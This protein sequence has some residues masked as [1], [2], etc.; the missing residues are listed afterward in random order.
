MSLKQIDNPQTLR[1]EYI[2][3]LGKTENST[4]LAKDIAE[5][6]FALD[7]TVYSNNFSFD[8]LVYNAFARS[9]IDDSI[10]LHPE[11]L[12]IVNH[13]RENDA[14]IISAPTSFGKTFCIFEYIIRYQPKNVVLIV[15][16]L[17]LVDEY[18]KKII[19]KFR[20]KFSL[21]KIH[22]S[23][24]EDK[25]YDF[26]KANIFILTH[27]RV[28]QESSYQ[29][30]E[31]IDFMVIDEVYK[32]ETDKNDDR[33][34]VLNM[35]YYYLSQKAEKYVLLAPFIKS[36]EDTDVLEKTPVF[37][38]TNYS[39]VVN[40]VIVNPILSESDRFPETKRLLG[41]L[42][43][44]D[45]TLIYFPTVSGMYNYINDVIAK[46]PLL[47]E[48][49][50]EVT[51]FIAWAREEIHEEWCLITALERGYLIHNGQIPVGT[52]I[53]QLDYYEQSDIYNKLLC[54]STL[55]E[56]VNTTAK[57]IIITKPSRKSAKPGEEPFSAFDFFNLVGRTGRL[58]KHYI[59]D[60]YYIKT[61]N[62]PEFRRADAIKNI[63]F[64]ITD[65]SVDIDI[66]KGNIDG[67]P[68]VI[69]FFGRL[70][71]TK[72]DYIANIGTKIR[73][74]NI[75][76]MYER[77]INNKDN[78]LI[79][80]QQFLDNDTQGRH[81]LVDI[82]Y[83]ICGGMYNNENLRDRRLTVS[84]ITGLL[85]KKRP[86]IKKVVDDTRRHFTRDINYL[87][88]EAIKIKTSFIEHTFYNRVT[89]IRYFLYLSNI[90]EQLIGVLDD[91]IINT[92]EFLYFS[93]VK[94]KKMLLDLGIY[95]RDI[96]KVIRVIGDD[97]DDAVELK[98]RL[99]DNLSKIKDVSYITMY[100]IKNII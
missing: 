33:V 41:R 50:P 79:A 8:S 24:S 59:G 86:R 71:I 60:A 62:D 11:Q 30:I 17:A 70:G 3:A 20:N 12:Q 32:L 90:R 15:P 93:N 74:N 100:I 94:H 31:K 63:K 36:V 48:L 98:Q 39:P 37:F 97:F 67:H 7:L 29:K 78:L 53:F 57:N 18:F 61:Q 52:R 54:T 4:A 68:E 83:L 2:R 26:T 6:L 47:E 89:I 99:T 16:T 40:E 22:T 38:N 56:G 43:P 1:D 84:L 28:V 34:L 42:K 82:L 64:E 76:A 21:Y 5:D 88:S 92:I 77:Y 23:I 87:I 46:E 66:Q 13:I 51:F 81:H 72:G 25:E 75:V 58:F 96:D 10:S 35:A 19:K 9:F 49:N 69:A 14:L 95:E 85:N 80:L 65:M 55:L 91:K 27:D 44:D 45:K 73:F